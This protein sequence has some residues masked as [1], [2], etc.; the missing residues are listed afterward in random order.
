MHITTKGQV[1]IPQDIRE[2][3][4]LLPHTTVDFKVDKNNRLYLVKT[5]EKSTRGAS[6]IK[7]MRGQGGIK[8]TT[9]EILALT[10]E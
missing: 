7:R 9:D 3:F 2:K 1:T 6:L 8:M 10:R 4:G 5:T